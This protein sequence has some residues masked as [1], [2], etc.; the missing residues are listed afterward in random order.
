M[1]F[2]SVCKLLPF[3]VQDMIFFVIATTHIGQGIVYK[4]I[5]IIKKF[6][7]KSTVRSDPDRSADLKWASY[8]R[9]SSAKPDLT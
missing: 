1:L 7:D 3:K 4:L 9:G 6:M 8:I 2:V 5:F